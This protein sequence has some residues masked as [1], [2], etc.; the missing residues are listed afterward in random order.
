MKAAAFCSLNLT[1]KDDDEL[2]VHRVTDETLAVVLGPHALHMSR[3]TFG[4]FVGQLNAH[5][6][7]LGI[8]VPRVTLSS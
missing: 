5:S 8:E 3:L 2:H 6:E 1:H 7:R 4:W